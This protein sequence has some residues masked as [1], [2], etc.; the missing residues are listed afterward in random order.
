LVVA[1]M[2]GTGVFTTS[3]PL[4][5]TVG[6]PAAVLMVW[7]V[8]G[9]VSLCGALSYAEIGTT[10]PEAGGEY[11]I[12]KHALHPA[13]GFAAGVVSIT[14]GFAAPIAVCSLAFSS[15][16]AT[17][18]PGL[19]EL[20]T[21]IALV[22]ATTLLH[23]QRAA[24]GAATQN[25]LTALKILLVIGLAVV[26]LFAIDPSRLESSALAS[27]IARPSFGLGVVQ[28]FFAYTGWNAAV[29][30]AGDLKDPARTLPRAL[31]LGT[32]FV[33]VIYLALN[34]AFVLT[35]PIETVRGEVAIAER[36][37]SALHGPV[38]AKGLAVVIAVGLISTVGAFVLSGTRVYRAMAD[39]APPLAF[40]GRVGASGAPTT[41]LSVQAAL[42]IALILTSSLRELLGAV[43]M[44]LSITSALTVI[45]VFVERRRMARAGEQP[46]FRA[47]GYPFTPLLYL[48][49]LGWVVVGGSLES[50]RLLVFSLGIL[51]VGGLGFFVVRRKTK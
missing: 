12:L 33:I 32:V 17:V 35:V 6:S 27:E 38:L 20:P 9:V 28:V 10:Y 44:A 24:M 40:L 41:A 1:S 45:A 25:G 18:V 47:P 4:L 48:G 30:V 37:M 29:Y 2:I 51:V 3:G 26:G 42:A 21:A 43:G 23:A 13:V 34:A 16:L 36:V 15:Y 11:A 39:D 5:E 50:P 7:L 14:A 46:A 31:L 49:L 8:G 22:L 19:P